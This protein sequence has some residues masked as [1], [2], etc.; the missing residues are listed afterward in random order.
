[1]AVL[2]RA[3]PK[4]R[5]RFWDRLFWV[6]LSR[7]WSRW[8]DVLVIVK[9]ETVIAWHCMGFRLFW[10][11]KSRKK[12]VGRPP[13]PKE[14]RDLIRQMC[15]ENPLWGAPRIH[16]E[17]LKL[18]INVSR[19]TVL[20]HMLRPRKPPSQTWRI[21]LDNHVDCLASMDFLV[22]R[23]ARLWRDVPT[24]A[25]RLL[26][27]FVVLSHERRRIVHFGVTKHPTSAWVA[28]QIREAFPWDITRRS[29]N[30]KDSYC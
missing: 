17:F 2:R 25:F 20:R 14:V 1:M 12:R 28:Q 5:L 26:Y 24:A 29:R 8:R 18:G 27:V 4:P 6:V 13:T 16:A 7:R 3:T 22:V 15:R 30:Q 19:A 21:V 23:I 9:P 11:Y 10:R